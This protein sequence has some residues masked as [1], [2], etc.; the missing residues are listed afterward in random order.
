VTPEGTKTMAPK[1]LTADTRLAIIGLGYVGLPLACEFSHKYQTAGFDI[2]SR[3]IEQIQKGIDVNCSLSAEDLGACT[4]IVFADDPEVLAGT[5]I[6]I[7]TAPTPVD[8]QKQPDLKPLQTATTQVAA[9]L[10]KGNLVIFESTV[11]PGATEEECVPILERVS[12]LR[13]NEDFFVGYSPERVNPGDKGHQLTNI[14]KVTSGSTPATAD[15]VDELYASIISAG[16]HRASSIKVAEAAKV[17]ENTQR[18]LNIALVNELAILFNKLGIDTQEV[19]SAAGSK[20]NFLGFTPGLVGG[21][22][23]GVDPYYL[24]YKA[25][26]LGYQPDVILAGRRINDSMGK[27]VAEQTIKLM[28]SRRLHV[29]DSRILILGMT[30]KENC[31]DTRNSRVPDIIKTLQSYHAN[32]EVYD[33]W[34]EE[35]ESELQTLITLTRTLQQGQYDAIIIAVAHQQFE[36]LG[37]TA[38]RRLGKATSVIYDVKSVFPKGSVDGKL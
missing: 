11:Y 26:Q 10:R 13:F 14:V 6:F 4:R 35:L 37:V 21:H 27:Y 24:T 28:L 23:I 36:E 19:L 1:P 30:F 29:T 25:L 20:W 12:G 7:I 38:I 18:D 31:P 22:C 33:P 32:V 9:Y 5:D 34:V 17:I 3:R 15:L 16:T 8:R 2:N